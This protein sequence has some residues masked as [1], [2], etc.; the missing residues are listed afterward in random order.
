MAW[1]NRGYYYRSVKVRGRVTREYYGKGELVDFMARIHAEERQAR[2]AR[3]A[4]VKAD[5]QQLADLDAT[6]DRLDVLAEA[7]SVVLLEE[8]GY[9]R[10][11]GQWRKRRAHDAA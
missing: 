7:V 1:D 3:A 6:L 8:A 11:K 2:Q 4:A 10:H 9:H 5:R